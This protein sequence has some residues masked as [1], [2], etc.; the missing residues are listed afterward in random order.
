MDDVMTQALAAVTFN[1]RPERLRPTQKMPS[2]WPYV[3]AIH[4]VTCPRCA[5]PP[6]F[7]CAAPSGVCPT[8]HR[9]RVT[10]YE[11][12]FDRVGTPPT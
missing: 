2:P 5:A 12:Q 3:N 7:R 8:P 9:E 4:Y 11:T 10:A 1:Y 6:R